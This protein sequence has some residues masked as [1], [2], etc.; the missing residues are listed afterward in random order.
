MSDQNTT[1]LI[2]DDE[3]DILDTLLFFLEDDY[4]VLTATNGAE[5]LKLLEP[6]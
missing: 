5:G 1:I 6:V 4:Q 2:V 3:P